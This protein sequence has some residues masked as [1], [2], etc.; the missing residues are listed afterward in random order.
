LIEVQYKRSQYEI[1]DILISA[2]G[3]WSVIMDRI[4]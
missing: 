3:R 2:I 1:Y 4:H